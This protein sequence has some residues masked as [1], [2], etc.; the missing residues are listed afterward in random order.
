MLRKAIKQFNKHTMATA[1]S[2]Q[3]MAGC[4]KWFNM[5]TGFGFLTVVRG[6]GSGELKVGSEVF[7]HHS[8]VKV[9]EEQ[10]R[11]LVQGEYVEFDVS[12]VA[13]GQ[14]SCQATN[15]TGMFGGKLMCETRNDARQSSSS[16]QQ[17]GRGDDEEESDGDAYVPVLRRTVSSAAAPAAP[18]S[19]R[20][21]GGDDA[22]RTRGRGGS[23]R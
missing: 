8:N 11:F 1:V 7:V 2:G 13:N 10:Y 23:H 21:R 5:K 20:S 4:V 3:K 9:Q 22:P 16:Q 19:F 15:V 6:G 17:G 14:H 18:S 12:N